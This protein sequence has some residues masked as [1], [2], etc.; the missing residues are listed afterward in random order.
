MNVNA[1]YKKVFSDLQNNTNKLYSNLPEETIGE[2]IYKSRMVGGYGR[3]E[4]AKLCS[5][6]YSS[7]CKYELG[8]AKPNQDNLK[9]ICE[10]LN[11]PLKYFNN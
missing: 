8:Y 7:I 3:R 11:L 2:K 5:V 9:K 1:T 4:F 6:G 10:A